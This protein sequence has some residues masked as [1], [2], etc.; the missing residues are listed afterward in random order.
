MAIGEPILKRFAGPAA[1]AAADA[2]LATVG[3]GKRWI[4]KQVVIVNNNTTTTRTVLLAKGTTA[5]AGNRWL[6]FPIPPGETAAF[7]LALVLEAADTINGAQGTGTDCT[8][9]I[10][11]VEQSIS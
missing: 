8:V 1:M 5:T 4:V 6:S 11:G 7:N 9:T 3:A 10:S 2:V